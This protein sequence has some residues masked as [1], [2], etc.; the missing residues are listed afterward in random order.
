LSRGR[1]RSL[2]MLAAFLLQAD[3]L[4]SSRLASSSLRRSTISAAT[5]GLSASLSSDLR[6]PR[7]NKSEFVVRSFSGNLAWRSRQDS[8]LQPTGSRNIFTSAAGR[9]L[10][11][12]AS[13]SSAKARRHRRRTSMSK[14]AAR[15]RAR[16]RAQADL[17]AGSLSAALEARGQHGLPRRLTRARRSA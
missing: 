4:S 10:E 12:T 3:H 8:N 14:S 15:F 2:N 5:A 9:P 1:A 16:E 6:H 13:R 7:E 11:G 17:E